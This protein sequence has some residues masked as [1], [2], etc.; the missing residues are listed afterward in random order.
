VVAACRAALDGQRLNALPVNIGTGPQ[1]KPARR[2]SPALAKPSGREPVVQFGAA[3]EGDIRHS[4]AACERAAEL[5]GFR[6]TVA[7]P[8]GLAA[9]WS[10]YVAQGGAQVR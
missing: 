9:T 6:S 2:A 4:R 3:R 5:L 7:F 10:W 1:T 8:E